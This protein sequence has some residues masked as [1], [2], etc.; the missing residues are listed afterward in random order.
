MMSTTSTFIKIKNNLEKWIK[1]CLA[2]LEMPMFFFFFKGKSFYIENCFDIYSHLYQRSGDLQCSDYGWL[3]FSLMFIYRS[4][5]PIPSVNWNSKMIKD[6]LAFC[7]ESP[8]PIT[9]F[10]F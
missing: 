2:F 3:L 4:I 9:K 7:L 10:F 8:I 5:H 6:K 1:Y